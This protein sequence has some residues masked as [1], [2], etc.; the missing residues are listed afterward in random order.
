MKKIICIPLF[1][2]MNSFAMLPMQDNDLSVVSGQS[3]ITI[4]ITTSSDVTVGEVRYEDAT[5]GDLE[6]DG[7]GSF[8]LRDIAIKETAFSFDID[9]S[10]AGELV[11]K[12]NNF[13]VTDMDIGALQFN[14][15]STLLAVDPTV[16]STEAQLRNQYSRLGSLAV[17]D[18]TLASNADIT[19][20]FTNQGELAFTAGMPTGSF[21]SSLLT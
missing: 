7:G 8:S 5:N 17:N 3:G 15:D 6:K 18:F 2:S 12:L 21:F 20:R 11:M 4:D 14:Y 16:E 13:A 10:A 1:C 19:F 9:V